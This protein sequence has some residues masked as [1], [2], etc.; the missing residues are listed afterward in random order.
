MNNK[1][2]EI[3]CEYSN[4]LELYNDICNIIFGSYTILET[5]LL[6]HGYSKE[7][8]LKDFKTILKQVTDEKK[9]ARE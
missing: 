8:V 1:P 2:N 6:K 9:G 4:S 7:D 5:K 3:H